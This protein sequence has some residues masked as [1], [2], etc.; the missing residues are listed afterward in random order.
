MTNTY[1]HSADSNFHNFKMFMITS[2]KTHIVL[3][4]KK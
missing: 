3:E 4:S 2:L 1:K